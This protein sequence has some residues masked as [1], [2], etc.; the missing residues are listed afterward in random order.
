[1]KKH[2]SKILFV[3]LFLIL[4][5]LLYK[6]FTM[7]KIVFVDTIQVYNKFNYKEELEKNL[8]K[9]T[10][11]RNLT[12]DNIKKQIANYNMQL[13]KDYSD[14]IKNTIDS[15]TVIFY[16]KQKEFNEENSSL[17]DDY[18]SKIWDRIN[19]YI[20]EYGKENNIEIILGANGSGNIMYA[21]KTIDITEE[22]T[23][24]I[25]KKYEGE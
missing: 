11:Q 19:N 18:N 14:N 23:N 24:Y 22:V 5:F 7:P 13:S 25:N 3:I 4:V 2:I 21:N 17:Q 10:E 8:S 12:L 6:E 1:M 9:I 15:L 20:D 16:Q